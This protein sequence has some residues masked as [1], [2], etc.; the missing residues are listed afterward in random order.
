MGWLRTF[1]VSLKWEY[2]FRDYVRIE[3][4]ISFFNAMNLANFDGPANPLSGALQPL[5]STSPAGFIN[6][7]SGQQPGGNR[8]GL[9]SG[10]FSQG[11]PRQLEFSLRIS[12]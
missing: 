7:T 3:P 6:S 4:G 12:F 2:K 9:G 10:V 5:G 8:I 11:A 1:D